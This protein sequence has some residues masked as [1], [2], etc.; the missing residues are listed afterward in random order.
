MAL[1]GKRRKSG[2]HALDESSVTF[3]SNSVGESSSLGSQISADLNPNW[4]PTPLGMIS[5]IAEMNSLF[6]IIGNSPSMVAE[7]LGNAGPD[8][9]ER[10]RI[11]N[12]SLYFPCLSGI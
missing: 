7:L 9:A 1:L 3:I 6:L 5:L 8:G 11:Q 4:K 12:I 10:A 2:I